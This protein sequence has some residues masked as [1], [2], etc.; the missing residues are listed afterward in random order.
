MAGRAG[1]DEG[2]TRGHGD[3]LGVTD[4]PTLLTGASTHIET[5]RVVHFKAEGTSTTPPQG[6]PWKSGSERVVTR[7][8]GRGLAAVGTS[9]APRPLAPS[10]PMSSRWLLRGPLP[11]TTPTAPRLLRLPARAPPHPFGSRARGLGPSPPRPCPLDPGRGWDG[12]SAPTSHQTPKRGKGLL[13]LSLT[14][15]PEEGGSWWG[16]AACRAAPPSSPATAQ[17]PH[18]GP[19]LGAPPNSPLGS[20]PTPTPWEGPWLHQALLGPASLASP[21]TP[22][23]PDPPRVTDSDPRTF[24][25][26]GG[27]PRRAR[28]GCGVQTGVSAEGGPPPQG[29]T[30]QRLS[31]PSGCPGG[32]ARMYVPKS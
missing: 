8:T 30:G 20:G 21:T 28:M 25:T 27:W 17:P 22:T 24:G 7:N 10:C 14:P 4:V 3:T 26:L 15:P 19:P 32:L 5:D 1:R 11:A 16:Q 13:R 6:C 9:G 12:Q 29:L 23:T 2:L 18:L 31:V